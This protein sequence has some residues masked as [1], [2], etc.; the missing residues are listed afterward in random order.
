MAA[1]KPPFSG[2]DMRSLKK[3][4]LGGV[5]KGIPNVYTT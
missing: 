2:N 5:Y 4:I 3:S 1:Q